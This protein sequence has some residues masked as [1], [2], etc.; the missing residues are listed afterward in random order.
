LKEIADDVRDEF[1]LIAE[2]AKVEL[3]G[4]QE[5]RIFV[6]YDNARLAEVGL[7]PFQLIQLMESRNI[8]IPGGELTTEDEK[9]ALE[10]SGNFETVDDLRRSVITVPGSPDVLY[11]EDIATVTRGYIDPPESKV[12]ATGEPAIA[13]AIS[14]REGG[15]IL[16]LGEQVEQTL[17]RLQALYPYGLELEFVAFQPREVEHKIQ[18]FQGNLIQAVVVVTAVMLLFLGLRT[19]LVVATLVPGA[20]VSAFFVMGVFGIGLDRHAGR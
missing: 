9:I 6:E 12:T 4:T 13:L 17:D 8:I 10:P 11:L 19:G 1:L 15:N 20:I 5:E 3:F 7:S 2:V 14:M 18:D 16:T